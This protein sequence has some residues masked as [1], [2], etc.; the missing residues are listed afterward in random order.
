[1]EKDGQ[2]NFLFLYWIYWVSNANWFLIYSIHC[3]EG[4][5]AKN[6]KRDGS[7]LVYACHP[8]FIGN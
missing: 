8:R 3:V 1:M 7:G 4:G 5:N 6:Q 2:F